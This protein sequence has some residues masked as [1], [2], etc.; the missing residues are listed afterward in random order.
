MS[1]RPSLIRSLS[2]GAVALALPLTGC[3]DDKADDAADSASPATAEAPAFDAFCQAVIAADAAANAL[4]GPDDPTPEAIESVKAAFEAVE[5]A[6][7]EEIATEVATMVKTGSERL[8]SETG[9]PGEGFAEAAKTTYGFVED[10]CGFGT[11]AVT[12]KDYSYDGMPADMAEGASL[13]TLKNAGTELHEMVFVRVNDDVTESTDELLALPEEEAMSKVELKGTIVA[14][15]GETTQSTVD[16]EA[17]RYLVACF[18]PVGL[19]PESMAS[20]AEPEGPPHFT[21][22]MVHD[23]TID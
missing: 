16:L 19:T 7:P 17:G 12:A 4:S 15:P 5:S 20:G 23:L 22:G 8:E 13:V 14:M 18:I 3:G 2:L 11:L 9:E 6:A 10:N 1:K 21:Q